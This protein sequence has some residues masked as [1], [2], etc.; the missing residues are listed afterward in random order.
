MP[1]A[2]II[3]MDGFDSYGTTANV[4]DKWSTTSTVAMSIVSGRYSG[5]AIKFTSSNSV[6]TS[7]ANNQF[8]CV[9]FAVNLNEPSSTRL[10]CTLYDTASSQVELRINPTGT[11][12]WT[13]NTI[14]ISGGTSTSMIHFDTWNYFEWKVMIADS[15]T[16]NSCQLKVNGETFINLAATSDTKNTA[17]AY[18]NKFE[19]SATTTGG[20]TPSFDDCIIQVGSGSDFLND[21]RIITSYPS[22]NGDSSQF[23]GS[24]GN[25]TDN[26]LLVDE[27]TPDDDS[28]YVE[29]ATIGN[30]DLYAFPTLGIT[31]NSIL[32][33]GVDIN[34]RKTDVG[35]RTLCSVVKSAS[36]EQDG[37]STNLTDS[38]FYTVQS[39][40]P[41]DPAT[42][43]AWTQSAVESAQIGQK[44]IA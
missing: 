16:S 7:F 36:T 3:F 38:Y 11:I 34:C 18:A 44:V 35:P 22:G 6:S 19:F 23:S 5:N 32:A 14:A 40:L 17:N 27:T 33:V 42:S 26:Y 37:T 41:T 2:N 21:A 43:S 10:L 12:S 25:S 8:I 15:I 29:S 30:K 20:M 28:T 1:A 31:A 24:D 9:S 4:P 39:I 13:R